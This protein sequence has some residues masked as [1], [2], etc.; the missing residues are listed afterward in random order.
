MD[1]KSLFGRRK[2]PDSSTA[3]PN[4]SLVEVQ[5]L[6]SKPSCL[7]SDYLPHLHGKLCYGDNLKDEW[8]VIFLLF[9]ASQRF[10]DLSLGRFV[11]IR[12]EL[13]QGIEGSRVSPGLRIKLVLAV[14]QEIFP[15]L[16]FKR[17]IMEKAKKEIR[18]KLN[19][20]SSAAV[21]KH[22]T[23]EEGN[24][25]GKATEGE[26]KSSRINDAGDDQSNCGEP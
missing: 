10:P 7:C 3:N 20:W 5:P 23:N 11:E 26:E 19:E 24:R 16:N 25:Y 18:K 22:A 12:R 2:K 17:N 9:E 1:F 13:Q 4:P 8:F 6:A 21:T 15:S 14:S